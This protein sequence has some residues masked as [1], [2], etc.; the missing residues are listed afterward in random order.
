MVY[1]VAHLDGYP[2]PVLT[3][4]EYTEVPIADPPY[5]HQLPENMDYPPQ[6]PITTDNPWHVEGF[7]G[8]SCIFFGE[9]G[10][11]MVVCDFKDEA[12]TIAN[13]LNHVPG[14]DASDIPHTIWLV[15]GK[16]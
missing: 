3:V 1:T 16:E 13:F 8:F 5:P 6:Q 11:P 15:T 12:D 10:F 9:L 2:F 14:F 7:H 4:E